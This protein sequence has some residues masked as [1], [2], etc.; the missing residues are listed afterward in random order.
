MKPMENNSDPVVGF[1][2][3]TGRANHRPLMKG[4]RGGVYHIND[5]G[6]RNYICGKQKIDMDIN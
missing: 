6:V 4:V 3:S 1:F 5:K 2:K